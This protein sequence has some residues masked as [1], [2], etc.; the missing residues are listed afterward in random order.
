MILIVDNNSLFPHSLVESAAQAAEEVRVLR[1]AA[2]AVP[3]IA[4]LSPS[5]IIL[6][7]GLDKEEALKTNGRI[8]E[9]FGGSTPM[10]GIGLGMHAIV[11]ASGGKQS[12]SERLAV[13]CR[14]PVVHDQRGVFEGIPSPTSAGCFNSRVVEEASLPRQLLISAHTLEGEIMAVR[15]RSGA[16]LEGLQFC[17]ESLLTVKG[18]DIIENFVEITQAGKWL[19]AM[20]S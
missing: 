20:E 19:P 15:Y 13:G 7:P 4:A 2:A 12:P 6:G 3:E 5:G 8:V 9:R 17:P 10:L 11:A 1:A 14:V 16:L 18:R